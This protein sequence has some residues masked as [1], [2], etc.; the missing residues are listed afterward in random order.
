MPY[1]AVGLGI[2][3]QILMNMNT[4]LMLKILT[5]HGVPP[6]LGI[7]EEE[8]S[9]S[10]LDHGACEFLEREEKERLNSDVN[11]HGILHHLLVTY[12][13]IHLLG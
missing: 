6:G 9:R 3:G 2:Y 8:I 5:N 12:N 10:S 4:A 7:C 11:V 1:I 13:R